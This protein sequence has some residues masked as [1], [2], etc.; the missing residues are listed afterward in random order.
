VAGCEELIDSFVPPVPFEMA[1]KP[2]S[3]RDT[4]SD[5]ENRPIKRRGLEKA[6]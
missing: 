6:H 2:T 1:P 4:L 3:A 5:T